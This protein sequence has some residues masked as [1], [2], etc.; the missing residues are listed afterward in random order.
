LLSSEE[1]LLTGT[2]RNTV[3]EQLNKNAEGESTLP[4][5]LK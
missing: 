5:S 2:G 1:A 4:P 3:I